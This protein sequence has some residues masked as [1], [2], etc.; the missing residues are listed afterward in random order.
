[1]RV[2]LTVLQRS[3]NTWP[4]QAEMSAASPVETVRGVAVELTGK[5]IANKNET[6]AAGSAVCLSSDFRI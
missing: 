1:M 4:A 5:D 6:A 3:E 2:R